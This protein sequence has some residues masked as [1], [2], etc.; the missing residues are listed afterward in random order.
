[1][2]TG[3]LFSIANSGNIGIGTIPVD[4]SKLYVSASATDLNAVGNNI[5]SYLVINPNAANGDFNNIYSTT[6]VEPDST[7]ALWRI[8]G[9]SS[10]LRNYG[11]GNIN[12]VE[13][14]NSWGEH[15]GAGTIANLTGYE[16]EDYGNGANRGKIT[17]SNNFYGYAYYSDNMNVTNNYGIKI[18]WS[19]LLDNSSNIQT[20]YGAYIGK[21]IKDATSTIGTNYG[22]YL[23]DQAVGSTS[24]AV[25]SN[26]GQ[27]YFAGNVGIG[28]TSPDYLLDVA[29]QIT[30]SSSYI[31]GLF[32]GVHASISDDFE[33]L[34]A[35]I[36]SASIGTLNIVTL[37]PANFSATHVSVSDD[38]TIGD[39]VTFSDSTASISSTLLLDGGL[40]SYGGILS[41]GSFTL[42]NTASMSG[43][44]DLNSAGLLINIGNSGTD[45][46]T[47]G[48]LTLAGAF[49]G[50]GASLSDDLDIT[51]DFNVAS[52]T[53]TT[54]NATNGL[55]TH[56]SIS[57]DLT[58]AN[59]ASI[60]A[61]TALFRPE[62]NS[63]TF[64][65][66]ASAA[67]VSGDDYPIFNVDT[68]NGKVGIGTNA[69]TATLTVNGGG[70]NKILIGNNSE[71][72]T[73]NLISLNGVR[74]NAYLGIGGG[75]GTDTSLFVQSGASG[76][77]SFRI[78]QAEKMRVDGSNGYL[79]IGDSSP[80]YTLSVDGTAS[81]SD[82][83]YFGDSLLWGDVSANTIYSSASW[84]ID[85]TASISGGLY[86]DT[87]AS[88][89]GDLSVASQSYVIGD[90]YG[91]TLYV[92]TI[93][94]YVGIGTNNP[95]SALSFYGHSPAITLNSDTS[96]TGGYIYFKSASTTK[97]Y[98]LSN[99]NGDIYLSIVTGNNTRFGAYSSHNLYGTGGVAGYHQFS[100]CLA[101]GTCTE[102]VRIDPADPGIEVLGTASIS[103]DL[104]ASG[105]FQFGG[106]EGIATASYSRLGSGTTGH[107]L[108]DADDLLITGMLEVDDAAYFDSS[109]TAIHASISDDLTIGT[110]TAFRDGYINSATG[111][112]S[113]NTGDNQPVTLGTG[114]L[115]FTRA[116]ASDSLSISDA[117]RV[118]QSLTVADTLTKTYS[119]FGSNSTNHGLTDASD[120][121]FS[122]KVEIDG[123]LY[124]D[125][126]TIEFVQVSV[127][128][129][130]EV[131]GVIKLSD[132]SATNP[133]YTFK[134]DTDTGMFRGGINVLGFTTA[135]SERLHIDSDGNVGIGTTSPDYLLDVAG[136]I[137]A[138][139]S[140]FKYASVSQD[141]QVGTNTLYVNVGSGS[142]DFGGTGT[143][144]FVGGLT[145]AG[146]T[147][148]DSGTLFVDNASNYVGI[149]DLSPSYTLSVD[150]TAS[151]SDDF[152][153]GGDQLFADISAS[154][155]YSSASWDI[156]GDLELNR[157]SLSDSLTIGDI[158]HATIITDGTATL[159]GG[160]FTGLTSLTSTLGTFTHASISDDLTIGSDDI[161]FIGGVASISS[162]LWLG[163]DLTGIRASLSDSLTL[164]D[165]LHAGIL[166][167]GTATLTGGAFTGLSSL[168]STA[169]SFTHASISDDLTIGSDDISFIGGVASISSTLWLG[170]DLTGIRAS[171]SDSLTLTDILHA[172][173]LTDGTATLTGGAFTGLSSLTS[174]A[175]SFTHASISDD[176]TI[177]DNVTFSDSLA[178]ISNGLFVDGFASISDDF[179][180]ASSEYVSGDDYGPTLYVDTVNDYVGIGIAPT[181]APLVVKSQAMGLALDMIGSQMMGSYYGSV[182]ANRFGYAMRR[183]KGT[184]NNP[185]AVISG[186][187]LG[188]LAFQGY[189]G[190]NYIQAGMIQAYVDD[191]VGTNSVP[192]RISFVT[193]TN[194][195]DRQER[196]TVKNTG[197]VGIGTTSPDYLLDVAGQ[198]TASSSYING[199]FTG[200][201]ASLSDDLTI[202]SDDVS[203]ING[204]ASISSTLWLGGDLTGIR[205]SLSDSLT[206]TDI[207][208]AG[209]LTDGTATLTGGN[210]TGIGS[211]TATTGTFTHASI[212]DD[213]TIGSDDISF[214]GGIAS[215]SST[216]WVG[217]TLT[218]DGVYASDSLDFDEFVDNATLD[219]N[220]VVGDGGNGYY[221]SFPHAS[222]SDD[223]SVTNR[224]KG[225]SLSDGTATLTG[226]AFTGLTSLTSTLGTF[227]HTSVSDDL[228]IGSDDVSFIGGVA[229]I[230][231]T[232]WVGG[233][234]TD[235]G[236]ITAGTLTDGT[237]SLTGG[238]F[239]SLIALTSTA[240]TGT[241][242]S[243]SDDLTIGSDDISFIG[244]VASISNTLWLG[245]DL[246]GVRASLSDSLTLTDI[247]HAGILTDGTAT[248]TGGNWTGIGSLTA[249]TGT[250]THASISD[251]LTIG[252]NTAF[253]D[254]Y[255][256]SATG[257]LSINTGNNQAVTFGT[258][259]LSFTRASVSDSLTLT[260]ILHAGILTDG[261]ATLTGG[262]FS[263]L[264]SLT[265]TLGTFTH[266]SISD[267]LTIGDNV[268]FSDSLASVSGNFLV[269]GS[270][271]I[272]S[273]SPDEALSVNGNINFTGKLLE[274]GNEFL[275]GVIA[276]FDVACPTGWTRFTALDSAFPRGAAVYGGTGGAATHYHNVNLTTGAT[277]GNHTHDMTMASGHAMLEGTGASHNVILQGSVQ[278]TGGQ[279]TGHTHSVSGSTDSES[280]LPPY[281][282]MVF[283]KKNAGADL[284]EWTSSKENYGPGTMV[285]LD[286]EANERVKIS[287]NPYD[288]T[289]VGVVS[290][291]PGWTIGNQ[292]DNS[293]MLALSGRV[294]VKVSLINGAI[295]IGDPIT[296]SSIPG[297][298]MKA[299]QS[300]AIV[301]K[302]M[303]NFDETSA[304]NECTDPATQKTTK[305]GEIVVFI[306][307]SWYNEGLNSLTIEN[308]NEVSDLEKTVQEQQ[309]QIASI[310]AQLAL[311]MEINSNGG[312][313]A[314]VDI[315]HSFIPSFTLGDLV[316]GLKELGIIIEK[317]IVKIAQLAVKTLVIEKNSDSG[318]SSIGEGV[319][320]KDSVSAEIKSNQ[321]MPTS[322]IF[323][324][325]RGDYGSRWWINYQEK[326]LAII[327]VVDPVVDDVKFDWWI[328]QTE[329]VDVTQTTSTTPS[330][331]VEEP[332]ASSSETPSTPLEV[333]SDT[334]P[335]D[336]ST[337]PTTDTSTPTEPTAPVT[338]PSAV[339]TE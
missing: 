198:I 137:T 84:N 122:G 291:A 83:F 266:A 297:T 314:E 94:D 215:I 52:A 258:G 171:L 219:N 244:G 20:N 287:E 49:S 45:F 55:F 26:G 284:A 273:A 152:Y 42:D 324:T 77:I 269:G 224:I 163:G 294:Q 115:S 72:P 88:I 93:N 308:P 165:I 17:N 267:D 73:Y 227:T 271:G 117:L 107:P 43:D 51:G 231:S 156:S 147:N 39:N 92:D 189:D 193:G 251:D 254:G 1:M 235:A 146:D 85:N 98:L 168:T 153:V 134:N 32:T 175:G 207:L 315:S 237:G 95:S 141:F 220:W 322:K 196:L 46:T 217:G 293:V 108:S 113:I 309:D 310:S 229:S 9:D 30:A 268:T 233:T 132:G 29:G 158:M 140:Y 27:S 69:P 172:G 336:T 223:L 31:N 243:I 11:S 162:T 161:S 201:H 333:P 301:G 109:L 81:I 10:T 302:A 188:Y 120:V 177:G 195:S 18:D 54:F 150:G 304:G 214:N 281:L 228:T 25:Y 240:L 37:S 221:V 76:T 206:L 97:S 41:S 279:S 200:V 159:T 282:D 40:N 160:A 136:Q 274:D 250:F 239:T 148:L 191:T 106:G 79:G 208:H 36:T 71:Y 21:P 276:M 154:T 96:T 226:G 143:A 35:N 323:I 230:S 280:S 13:V 339:I 57:D 335:A 321:I 78:N 8:M 167:D 205:A 242:A 151:I 125:A 86:V 283:C 203:F 5:D 232:L 272:A 116:S 184:Y 187:A 305:C 91:P 63:I 222:S 170:G 4:Y 44:F 213:L 218:A 118:G 241:H 238:T 50:V 275:S 104:W 338:E 111:A 14:V 202:G 216:L 22:I 130:F 290:T 138:S 139:S 102:A 327:N 296:T 249:T 7:Q 61:N 245:G 256:N 99:P 126:S 299:I 23:G 178:S 288:S 181:T 75:G 66:V 70:T 325:F 234:L 47:G 56:A 67:F 114:L 264:I 3:D 192:T 278:T 62:T 209:I 112:L 142:Y 80:A 204:V 174:T 317:G 289:L 155:I 210:W 103:E 190:A 262:A 316:N 298:G 328:V 90:D 74:T 329:P 332:V 303:A 123:T 149:G 260:D 145:V 318:Q 286:P 100:L 337:T 236:T 277:S 186:D 197:N 169:G 119:S 261:T 6:D 157:A 101:N 330:T 24:Y 110:N 255:I 38:L 64:F 194:S 313:G 33:T 68:I 252:T 311:L 212:S 173:I 60:S 180:V 246:T 28:T 263:G 58:I 259:L 121:L 105:S 265:S 12:I 19:S 15:D 124:L 292:A 334:T 166:T 82:D 307:V 131:G 300:G 34:S 65:Q 270:I 2:S 306:G 133:S 164:T 225:G 135:G 247:L 89:S 248:L 144:S 128:E 199:L 312:L 182:A 211:L 331:P 183:G 253:R 16:S 179:S 48:G 326:G 59:V 127:S 295:K 176:L 257:T 320:P 129:D 53:I 319:I 285:V 87:L 185:L